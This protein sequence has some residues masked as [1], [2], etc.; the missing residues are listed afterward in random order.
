MWTSYSIRLLAKKG[1]HRPKKSQFYVLKSMESVETWWN[2]CHSPCLTMRNNI[3]VI[4]P[5]DFW[6]GLHIPSHTSIL[7]QKEGFTGQKEPISR[8]KKYGNG[9]IMMNHTPFIMSDHEESHTSHISTWFLMW[10][11]YSISHFDFKRKKGLHG[12]KRANFTS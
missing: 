1:L 4:F 8:P 12:S 5:H 10:A 9:R 7:G 3:P 11:S 6:C 2:T